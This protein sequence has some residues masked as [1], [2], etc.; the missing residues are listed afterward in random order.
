MQSWGLVSYASPLPGGASAV[1]ASFQIY[2]STEGSLYLD[3]YSADVWRTPVYSAGDSEHTLRSLFIPFGG[4][5]QPAL[6]VGNTVYPEPRFDPSGTLPFAANS[7]IFVKLDPGVVAFS[8]SAD[9]VHLQHAG[10]YSQP[11]DS[12]VEDYAVEQIMRCGQVY[13]D[14][15]EYYVRVTGERRV[16]TLLS[17]VYRLSIGD[18]T[19]CVEFA[20]A[21]DSTIGV[22]WAIPVVPLSTQ[23]IPNDPRL[24]IHIANAYGPDIDIESAW[25]LVGTHT[26]RVGVLDTGVDDGDEDLQGLVVGDTDLYPNDPFHGTHVAGILAARRGNGHGTAGVAPAVVWSK[27]IY[28][29]SYDIVCRRPGSHV[30]KG[31]HFE[32]QQ[33]VTERSRLPEH[34]RRVLQCERLL[35]SRGGEFN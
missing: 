34:F 21:L 4:N 17:E 28:P 16:S 6:T 15:V 26:V 29:S 24:G 25:D 2:T 11:I 12:L 32:F 8:S 33:W 10:F 35:C 14:S 7:S 20:A 9:I 19:Q 1:V 22:Q 30:V 13:A 3:R 23:S 5:G 18:S 27:R 31:T